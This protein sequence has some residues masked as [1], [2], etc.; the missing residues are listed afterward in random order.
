MG[1]YALS[2]IRRS[3][4]ACPAL[5]RDIADHRSGAAWPP[6]RSACR[7]LAPEMA[8]A[9][10]TRPIWLKACGKLP[11]SSPVPGSTSSASKPVAHAVLA[12]RRELAALTIGRHD[13]TAP[14]LPYPASQLSASPGLRERPS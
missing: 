11:S 13:L 7:V 9:A 1:A 10:L 2:Q 6:D 3:A 8:E 14:D 12:F 5:P 4:R